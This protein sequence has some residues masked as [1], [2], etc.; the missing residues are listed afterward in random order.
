M[1]MKHLELTAV[2][3]QSV[4]KQVA[5]LLQIRPQ[6]ATIFPDHPPVSLEAAIP[7]ISRITYYAQLSTFLSQ[8]VC[9]CI[10]MVG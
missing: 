8:G 1:G 6:S 4:T 5:S 10:D 7:I 3:I 2:C 9:S